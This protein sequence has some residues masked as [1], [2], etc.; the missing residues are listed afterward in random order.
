METGN[1]DLFLMLLN[2]KQRLD[3]KLF[4]KILDL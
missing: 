2:L 3:Q 1:Y 4:S